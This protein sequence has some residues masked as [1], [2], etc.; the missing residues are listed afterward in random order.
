LVLNPQFDLAERAA[1]GGLVVVKKFDKEEP[2]KEGFL[3][4]KLGSFTG[5]T[6]TIPLNIQ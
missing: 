4:T 1:E 3:V 2:G 5:E 6:R